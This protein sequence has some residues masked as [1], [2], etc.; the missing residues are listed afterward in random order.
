MYEEVQE[1]RL[2][3]RVFSLALAMTV[4]AGLFVP[5]RGVSASVSVSVSFFHDSLAP[6]GDW[7]TVP[8]YGRC[9]RPS[10]VAFGWQPYLHGKWAYTD[11]GWAWVSFDP[12]GGDPYHYGTWVFTS[13]HGWIWIPG[14][15]WAPAWVTW[16][17]SDDYF[18]W[19]PVP[20]SFVVGVSGYAGPAVTVSRSAYVFVP[21]RQFAGVDVSSVRVPATR[22]AAV[23][24]HSR[25]VTSFAVRGG[26]LSSGGPALGQ[27]ERFSGRRIDRVSLGQ[28]R[29]QAIP[30]R[31]SL[32]AGRER[33]TV[34]VPASER[35]KAFE[36]SG[37]HETR[38]GARTPPNDARPQPQQAV[39]QPPPPRPRPEATGDQARLAPPHAEGTAGGRPQ[40]APQAHAEKPPA[41][42]PRPQGAPP[43]HGNPPAKEKDKEHGKEN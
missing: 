9:W 7:I 36:T 41:V 39:R 17:I 8:R 31:T 10:H 40:P 5:A 38:Q 6:Y 42:Q 21:A 35:A 24:A 27:V 14:T 25:P 34:V 37:R 20:P 28:A 12:W 30:I 26:V 33:A 18:G 19:A 43:A 11:V 1:M 2:Q 22:N 29:T 32:Q 3:S 23:V 15:V 4:A 13:R 16:C